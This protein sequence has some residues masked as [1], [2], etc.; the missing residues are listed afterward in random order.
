MVAVKV[1]DGGSGV[2]GRIINC[3]DYALLH[4]I[5]TVSGNEIP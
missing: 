3:T 4:D 1:S 5:A 2:K